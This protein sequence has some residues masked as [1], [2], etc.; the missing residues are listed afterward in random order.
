[1]QCPICDGKLALRNEEKIIEYKKDEFKIF[2]IYYQCENCGEKI[3]DTEM[4]EINTNQVYN[5]YREK[6]NIFFPQEIEDLR[7][8]YGLNK[9]KM[10]LVL[11]WGENTYSLYEKG[12]MPNDSHNSLLKLIQYPEQFIQLVEH[13]KEIFTE[14]ELERLRFLIKTK[15]VNDEK[16]KNNKWIDM[17]WPKCIKH[18]T[19]YVKPNFEKFAAMVL[20][21][22]TKKPPYKTKLNKLLFY[23]DFCYYKHHGLGISG[24]RY[25]AIEF[26]PVPS[27]Y[28][29]IYNWLFKNNYIT[30]KEC[31]ESFGVTEVFEPIRKFDNELFNKNELECLEFVNSIFIDYSASSLRD[32]SHK[33]KAWS[34]NVGERKI[35]SYQ[36]YAFNLNL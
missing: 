4:G 35:I 6:Y 14:K 15:I 27:E 24:S 23:S 22:L 31:Y 1:M 17:V 28:D 2:E 13:K 36:D 3:V 11:G 8:S 19:G 25:R 30:I 20:F 32:L 29:A 12:A 26:G 7:E 21:F 9:T 16:K 34:D 18:D 10:S 33:E 5:Q